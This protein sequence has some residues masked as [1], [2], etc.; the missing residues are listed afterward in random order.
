MVGHERDLDT[1]I[2]GTT[3]SQLI[4]LVRDTALRVGVAPERVAAVHGT[5]D[6]TL[7]GELNRIPLASLVRL[8]EM[9]AE[10]GS[11]VGVAVADAATLGT[12]TTWDYLVTTG[13][14]LAES[15]QAAQPYH[16]LVTAAAEGFDLH[17]DGD[18]T[19]G[20]RT[21]ADGVAAS[22]AINEY[23]LA[24]YLRRAR[25]ATGR[26][27]TPTR[28]TFGHSAPRDHS[29]LVDAFGTARIEFD[30]PADSITFAATDAAA[31]LPR[32]DPML[33]ELLRSHADLVLASARPIPGPL[34]AFR[35][36]LSA[37]IAQGDPALATVARRLAM[38][39]RTLQRHLAEHQTTWR[40]EFDQARYEQARD[41][42]AENRLTTAAIATRLGFADDRALRKAM[43]R[44][45]GTSASQLRSGLAL[46]EGHRQ[47]T[48]HDPPE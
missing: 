3:S 12:L 41:L 15:L 34:E 17:H 32:A 37:S 44:W 4:H 48:A 38:S 39:P 18:L 31:P 6:A 45:T 40:Q 11:G 24:Y 30:A 25:E 5:D 21:T 19:I 20:Y 47:T 42:L 10:A 1:R 23:V 9:L 35:I 8:W 22:A 46:Q 33:A 26:Q 36:A 16:R 7:S 13:P 43:H 29:A 14:T 2:D 28:V 27:V